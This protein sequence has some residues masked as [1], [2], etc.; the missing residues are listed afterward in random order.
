MAHHAA[1]RG[2]AGAPPI[3]T[4]MAALFL[5]RRTLRQP[6]TTRR[7][8]ASPTWNHAPWGFDL[9]NLEDP[10][11]RPSIHRLSAFQARSLTGRLCASSSTY[12]M[13]IGAAMSIATTLTDT[14]EL[15]H[16]AAH[17]VEVALLWHADANFLSVV[18]S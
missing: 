1:T 4:S 15:D 5:R 8:E 6:V 13:T 18:V 11:G 10:A 17:G 9:P 14:R 3:I 2:L 7:L 12:R 16:R